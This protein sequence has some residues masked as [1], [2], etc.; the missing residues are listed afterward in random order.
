[1]AKIT[2]VGIEVGARPE[3]VEKFQDAAKEIAENLGVQV[4][5][6]DVRRNTL[7][8]HFPKERRGSRQFGGYG[9]KYGKVLDKMEGRGEWLNGTPLKIR[10]PRNN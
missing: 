3:I 9:E 4:E 7:T 1:M 2:G 8:P 5:V 10:N 6:L